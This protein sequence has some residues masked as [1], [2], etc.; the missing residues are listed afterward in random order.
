MVESDLEEIRYFIGIRI[1]I[2][3]GKII[4]SQS[5]YVKKI[6]NK[7][8]MSDCKSVSTPLATKLNYE[9]LNSDDWY[10]APCRNLVGCLMY[11][12]LCTRLLLIF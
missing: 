8:K 9:L 4:L 6:L 2:G 10:D 12:M 11:V 3:D 7:F 1:E 5:A